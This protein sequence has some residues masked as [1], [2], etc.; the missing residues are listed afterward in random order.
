MRLHSDSTARC[1]AVPGEIERIGIAPSLLLASSI[2][3]EQRIQ[4]WVITDTWGSSIESRGGSRLRVGALAAVLVCANIIASFAQQLPPGGEPIPPV[5]RGA[6]GKIEVIPPSAQH[7][8]AVTTPNVGARPALSRSGTSPLD[9]APKT[10][11]P[12]T[13]QVPVN[14]IPVSGAPSPPGTTVVSN[15]HNAPGWRHSH[16]YTYTDGPY[17]RVVN[18]PGWDESNAA[19]NPGQTL[20]AYQLTSTGSCRSAANGGPTGTGSSI[21]DGT[22]TWKYLS[23]VDY[24][25]LTGWAFDNKP[26]VHGTAY[27]NRDYVTSDSPLRSY[28]V[29]MDNGCTSTVAPTGTGVNGMLTTS[30]GCTWHYHA[31]VL[32]SSRRT[33]IPVMSI[34]GTY[35]DYQYTSNLHANYEADLWN[36]REYVAGSRGEL[37]PITTGTAHFGTDGLIGEGPPNMDAACSGACHHLII[38]TAPGESFRGK[39]TPDT[40]LAGYDPSA[41]VAI[42]GEASLF[43]NAQGLSVTDWYVDLIGLQIKSDGAS[44]T[45]ASSV[46]ANTIRNSLLEGTGITATVSFD[47]Y[48][49]LANSLVISHGTTGVWSKYDVYIL[50]S[51][52]VNPDHTR[53]SIGIESYWNGYGPGYTVISNTGVFGFAHATGH[54]TMAFG[55]PATSFWRGDHNAT[56]SSATDS[57]S[58][59]SMFNQAYTVDPLPGATYGV[60][61]TSAFGSGSDWRLANGSLLRGIGSAFGSFSS[62][63]ANCAPT[64]NCAQKAIYN[65][66]TPDIIGTPRPQ[67]DRYDIGAWQS[68]LA[69]PAN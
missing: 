63:Q 36:D 38:T 56:D 24:I 28:G 9:A 52:I 15:I 18:G 44:A 49:V 26:W 4:P 33:Y 22:C 45:D 50:H 43:R 60:S 7:P 1:R 58:L 11:D 69:S 34:S 20:E 62:V 25:S 65:F 23:P 37:A 39:I 61:M 57:G 13:Q 6:D 32:Y 64:S 8:Q 5:R 59:T 51:T 27:H 31:E 21:Q 19:Y 35:P 12:P 54:L 66:D 3:P 14:S 47:C 16:T 40:T 67:A 42:H 55:L 46:C 48:G 10:P 17:T 30:D 2:K 29:E 41:G 68:T 53:G